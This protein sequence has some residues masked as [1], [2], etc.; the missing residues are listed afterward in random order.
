MRRRLGTVDALRCDAVPLAIRASSTSAVRPICNPSTSLHQRI[1]NSKTHSFLTAI[2]VP[3]MNAI[4]LLARR[5]EQ[6][7]V[8]ARV[9]TTN[10]RVLPLS[11]LCVCGW[12]AM[13]TNRT[14][15]WKRSKRFRQ[16]LAAHH[17]SRSRARDGAV[18]EALAASTRRTSTNTTWRRNVLLHLGMF[19]QALMKG[20]CPKRN[21]HT[22][23]SWEGGRALVKK[24]TLEGKKRLLFQKEKRRRE[25]ETQSFAA[26]THPLTR[27][28]GQTP[29]PAASPAAPP[30]RSPAPPP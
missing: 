21:R 16:A 13:V 9:V 2:V 19:D 12:I 23:L 4:S 14:T 30:C 28:R 17:A 24:Q 25:R 7:E 18:H 1:T 26:H 27:R 20:V 11:N 22:E 5:D 10:Q 15:Q 6:G 8:R 3:C 29:P